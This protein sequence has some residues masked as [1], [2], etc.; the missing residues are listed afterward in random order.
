MY[1]YSNELY[2]HGVKGMKW[3]VRRYQNA[4]GSLTAK[5]K[6]RYSKNEAYREKLAGRALKK[7]DTN[8]KRAEEARYNVRDLKKRGVHSDAYKEWQKEQYDKRAREYESK[9][10][11]T[12]NDGNKYVKKYSSSGDYLFDSIF[13]HIGS[14]TKVQELIDSNSKD[15]KRYTEAA[16][17]WTNNNEKLMNMEVSAITKKSDIRRVFHS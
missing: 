10:T 17:R 12:D 15:A 6:K 8:K 2:H 13:D 5:G 1:E 9:H 11:M 16:K 14:T 3:G 4:D 7:A